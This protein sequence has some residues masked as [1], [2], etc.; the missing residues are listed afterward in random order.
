VS[1]SNLF[2]VTI[3]SAE[4]YAGH[5]EDSLDSLFMFMGGMHVIQKYGIVKEP[6]EF[7]VLIDLTSEILKISADDSVIESGYCS[8]S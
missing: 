7:K 3:A 5:T 4:K 2:R 6:Y 1:V 8:S